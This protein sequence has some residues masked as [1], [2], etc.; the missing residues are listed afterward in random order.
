MRQ[1][2]ESRRFDCGVCEHGAAIS[3]R[4][5][6]RPQCVNEKFSPVVSRISFCLAARGRIGD[7]DISERVL[8][9]Q[10]FADLGHRAEIEGRAVFA[11]VIEVGEE[12]QLFGQQVFAPSL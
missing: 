6:R 3:V 8:P 5:L 1:V 7:V 10:P 9:S 4:W 12:V 2:N 11:G